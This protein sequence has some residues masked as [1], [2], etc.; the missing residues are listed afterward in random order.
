MT[1]EHNAYRHPKHDAMADRVREGL[2]DLA[3]ARELNADRRAVA[4]VRE[5]LGIAPMRNGTEAGDKLDRFSLERGDGHV[6][7]T[8]RRGKSGVPQI[9]HRGREIPAAHVAFERRTGR[10]PVGMCRAE[11]EGVEHC[12]TPEHVMDDLERRTVRLQLRELTGLD[13][14]WEVCPEGHP[15]ATEGRVEPDLTIYCRQ[16]NTDRARRTRGKK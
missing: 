14:P 12:L 7:W 13:G 5:I 4:R 3:V 9:R 2:T 15:W 16:C 11:C 10:A 6:T 8:G 1:N